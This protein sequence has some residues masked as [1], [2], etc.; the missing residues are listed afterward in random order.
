MGRIIH[1]N[2]GF[3]YAPIITSGNTPAFGTPV[4]MPGMVSAEAEVEQETTTIYA[5]NEAYCKIKGAKAR[6]ITANFRYIPSAYLE[7]LGFKT[8]AN[9]GV[10]DTGS[11][12]NHCIFFETVEE[13]CETGEE[14]R[15]LHYFY[16]VTG[17]EPSLSTTTDEDEV[18]A[19]ELEVEYDAK[20]SAIALDSDGS[21]AQYFH[22]TRTSDNATLYDTYT[23]AVILPTATV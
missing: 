8:Q 17:T 9:G 1:G 7:F 23:T 6:T 19:V 18:E 3:G 16:N 15:T 20:D 5:D 4:L 12:P 11:F 13:D 14:T 10:A 21:K 2:Q 22:I